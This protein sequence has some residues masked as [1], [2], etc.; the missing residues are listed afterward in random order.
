M[1]S[2]WGAWVAWLSWLAGTTEPALDPLS[3]SRTAPP[4]LCLSLK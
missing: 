2:S 1:I 3:P 4:Q